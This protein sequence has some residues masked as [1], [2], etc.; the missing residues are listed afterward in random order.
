MFD[1]YIAYDDPSCDRADQRCHYNDDTIGNFVS[2]HSN[3][4]NAGST[5]RHPVW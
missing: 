5:V 4:F 3:T 1:D 2:Y